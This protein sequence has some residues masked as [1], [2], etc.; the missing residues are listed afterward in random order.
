MASSA[1][2]TS[3]PYISAPG[4]SAPY[5][6]APYISA[7]GTL[8]PYTSA[9]YTSA[10]NTNTQVGMLL[11]CG[12]SDDWD[13][14]TDTRTSSAL[15]QYTH[16]WACSCGVGCPRLQALLQLQLPLL[17]LCC[18]WLGLCVA[19]ARATSTWATTTQ[20]DDDDASMR[21]HVLALCVCHCYGS[22]AGGVGFASLARKLL[23][24]GLRSHCKKHLAFLFCRACVVQ[25]I[26]CL[27]LLCCWWLGPCAAGA[28]GVPGL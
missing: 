6:L 3:A 20:Q 22:A 24:L 1:P 21:E 10:P 23:L 4:T 11:T 18:W 7:P 9:P 2:D 8:A 16:R 26:V 19:G 25:R 12:V 5:T 13:E 27:P 28:L 14:P 17:W 15:L